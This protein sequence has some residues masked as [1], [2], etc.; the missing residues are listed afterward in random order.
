MSDLELLMMHNRKYCGEIAHNVSTLKRKAIVERAAEV[1]SAEGGGQ[2]GAGCRRAGGQQ[3]KRCGTLR[4]GWRSIRRGAAAARSRR[5]RH[6]AD[7]AGAGSQSQREGREAVSQE[8]VLTGARAS[9]APLSLQLN[10][11][12]TNGNSRLR[13]Q[14]DE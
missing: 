9:P 10:V 11:K 13:S 2:G 14:E 1:R 12:L 8:Q 4:G 3:Q 6:G 5:P 7:R